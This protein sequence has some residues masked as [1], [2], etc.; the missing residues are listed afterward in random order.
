[1]RHF[2]PYR[3]TLF[4]LA[5]TNALALGLLAAAYF[6]VE[7][8]RAQ[9]LARGE[10]AGTGLLPL[11][12]VAAHPLD[13][14]SAFDEEFMRAAADL[15]AE[16]IRLAELGARRAVRP[17][18][19]A[20]ARELADQQTAARSEIESLAAQRGVLLPTGDAPAPEVDAIAGRSGEAFDN[21]FVEWAKARHGTAVQLFERAADRSLD[22]ELR[23]F[24]G[25]MLLRLQ[26]Q[27]E[28]ARRLRRAVF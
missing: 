23:G 17:E 7:N 24:A 27:H 3:G 9:R 4:R 19:Q 5:L 1:M 13:A 14:A 8:F 21:E 12:S 26:A 22:P 11:G 15:A 2:A 10:F 18:V 28:H 20:F 25:R 16:E 6:Q